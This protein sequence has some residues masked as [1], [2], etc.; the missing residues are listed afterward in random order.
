SREVHK[1]FKTTDNDTLKQDKKCQPCRYIVLS[2]MS[3]S[4]TVNDIWESPLFYCERSW[5]DS[6]NILKKRELR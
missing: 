6:V 1:M 3:G 4:T 2:T 5:S